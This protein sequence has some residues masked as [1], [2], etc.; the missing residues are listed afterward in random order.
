MQVHRT[1]VHHGLD[2]ELQASIC[3]LSCLLS[4]VV[5]TAVAFAAWLQNL[6]PLYDAPGVTASTLLPVQLC[7][8]ASMLACV[9]ERVAA[10]R[11]ERR[12]AIAE[13][14]HRT[15]ATAAIGAAEAAHGRALGVRSIWHRRGVPPHHSWCFSRAAQTHRRRHAIRAAPPAAWCKRLAF[16]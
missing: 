8:G 4:A 2:T 13:A 10:R 6:I 14:Q 1:V 12:P 11:A 16:M 7:I 9:T 3:S 5:M 15:A